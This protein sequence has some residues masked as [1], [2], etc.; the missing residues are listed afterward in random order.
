MMSSSTATAAV[1]AQRTLVE[2]FETTASRHAQ[3]P[4]LRTPDGSV[5]WT[6]G[7]YAAHVRAAAAGLAGLGLRHGDTL[8]CWLHNR[9]EFHVADAAALHLGAAAFSIYTTAAVEQAEH[10]LAD[11]GARII[12]TEPAFLERVLAVRDRGRTALAMIVL[13]DGAHAEALSWEELLACADDGFDLRAA[14]AAVQPD[15][16]ATLIYTSGTTGPPKGVQLTHANIAALLAAL[17]QRL[18]HPPGIS[19]L[20]YLP[21]AHIAERL[22]T[23]YYPMALGWQV[24]T[25]P[26]PR[27][28][29]ELLPRVRPHAFFSPPRLWEKLRAAVL[30]SVDPSQREAIDAAVG[31][32]RAGAGV[33]DGP[34]QQALRARLGLDRLRWAAVGAAPCPPAVLDFWHALGVGVG[35]LYGMSETTGVATVNPPEAIRIGTVGTPLDGVEIRLSESGEVLMRGPIV[36]TGYRNLPAATADTIDADGWLHSGDIGTLDAD[37]YL[38]IIGRIKELIINAAGKNMSPVSIESTLTGAG[39]L[40]AQAC[41]IGDAWPYN[42]ALL[43]LDPDPAR[44]V[45]PADLEAAVAAQVARANERLARAEQL[46]RFTV[47]PGEWLPDSDELTPTMKLKREAIA[48]KYADT[49]DALYAAATADG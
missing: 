11:A 34:V 17:Q 18:N 5:E 46:K 23:H 32:V 30:A 38:R 40:I 8:A 20:S 21:M 2:A 28:V 36:M 12:V 42:V 24:T 6:W 7:E 29:A 15:D 26:D 39:D 35:E 4:A 10:A 43:T 44:R 22:S 1:I 37:G 3:Q 25:C 41:V 33:Q 48:A 14:M 19:V 31:R 27:T 9:P 16:L 47:L 49:I 45:P 13:V